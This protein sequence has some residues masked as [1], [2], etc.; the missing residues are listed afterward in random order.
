MAPFT[1]ADSSKHVSWFFQNEVSMSQ[2]DEYFTNGLNNSEL[3]G[4]HSMHTLEN[5]FLILYPYSAYLQW[6]EGHVED[7][8]RTVPF[9]H[10]NVQDCVRYLLRQIAYRDDLVY[11]WRQEYDHSGNRVYAEMH[12]MDWWWDVQVQPTNPFYGNPG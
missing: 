3:A 10:R 1:S 6:V 11:A 9:F 5:H 2:I 4:Y 8:C 12:T 7:G